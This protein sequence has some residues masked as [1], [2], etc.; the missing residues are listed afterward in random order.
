L[1]TAF[2]TASTPEVCET[3][4]LMIGFQGTEVDGPLARRVSEPMVRGVIWFSRNIVSPMQ[5]ARINAELLAI[6]PDLIIAV[7]Q[8]GGAVR[9]LKDGVSFVPPMREVTTVAEA[10]HY[11][12]VLASM[13]RPLDF[14]MNLAP[15]LDVDSNPDNPIIGSRSFSPDPQRVSQLAIALMVGQRSGGLLSC[16]KHFPGHGDTTIDSHLA[17]PRIDHGMERLREIELVPFHGAVMAGIEAIM[18]AHILLPALDSEHPATLSP[19][20]LRILR[21]DLGFTGAILSDDLEMHA[22]SKRYS[23]DNLIELGLESGIDLF[24]VCSDGDKQDEAI[25]ALARAPAGRLEESM[26]RLGQLRPGR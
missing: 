16:G 2:A 14:T 7:D 4:M 11:G 1:G 12:Q 19:E 20:V 21:E 13:L 18:T 24:L 9:R 17:L 26:A 23:M 10:F 5:V 6:R 25:A 22:V 15:V 8:E 3:A